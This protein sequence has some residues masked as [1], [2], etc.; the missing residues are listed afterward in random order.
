MGKLYYIK[1]QPNKK[2]LVRSVKTQEQRDPELTCSCGHMKMTAIYRTTTEKTGKV[3]QLKEIY[4]THS[5]T[6]MKVRNTVQ[7]DSYLQ[8]GNP[9]VGE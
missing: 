2:F 8:V 1:N 6:G 5:K 3:L 9:Q 4:K 7:Y